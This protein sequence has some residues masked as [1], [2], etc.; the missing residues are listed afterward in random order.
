M[1]GTGR[2]YAERGAM[3]LDYVV[4]LKMEKWGVVHLRFA[5]TLTLRPD[6]TVL[7][8]AVVTKW[9]IRLGHVEIVMTRERAP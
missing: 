4:G 3:R 2:A 7:N 9:G 1:I 6:G 8:R 5:D